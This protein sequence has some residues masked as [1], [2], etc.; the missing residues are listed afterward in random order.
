MW[1]CKESQLSQLCISG[2]GGCRVFAAGELD[3]EEDRIRQAGGQLLEV[4]PG[5]NHVAWSTYQC[6]DV[7]QLLHVQTCCAWCETPFFRS[8]F[9]RAPDSLGT[10]TASLAVS[11]PPGPKVASANF[12]NRLKEKPV[13]R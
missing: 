11:G 3:V 9:Q 7:L 5:V 13:N 2:D 8:R 6:A 1:A 12:E 10:T 4:A